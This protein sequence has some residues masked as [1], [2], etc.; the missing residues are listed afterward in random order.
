MSAHQFTYPKVI[1]V[2]T[3]A[4]RPSSSPGSAAAAADTAGR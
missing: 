1:P 2:E 3:N 4:P